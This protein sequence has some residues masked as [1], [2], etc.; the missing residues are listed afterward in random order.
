M[1]YHFLYTYEDDGIAQTWEDIYSHTPQ[2]LAPGDVIR[3]DLNGDGIIDGKD[4]KA[5][6]NIQRDSPTTTFGLT[7]TA[8]WKDLTSQYFLTGLWDVKIIG[9][10]ISIILLLRIG[11]MLLLG[12]IGL[13]LGL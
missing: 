4:R 10:P 13:S 8:A 5:Y 7:L 2:G 12:I 9:L 11:V 6:P 3:K 1:P